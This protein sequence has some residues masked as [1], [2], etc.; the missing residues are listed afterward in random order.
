[1][2]D[3]QQLDALRARLPEASDEELTAAL[4]DAESAI[5]G[6]RFPFGDGGME[7]ETKYYGLQ[8]RIAVVL[9]NKQGAEGESAH[10]EA[11]VSRT[12]TSLDELL[13]EVMPRGAVL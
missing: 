5:L 6:K 4:D 10:S 11:G 13:R 9:Y 7:L 12:Y 3:P 1:M 8:L 2:Y